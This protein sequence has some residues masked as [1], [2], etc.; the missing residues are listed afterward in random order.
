MKNILNFLA[1]FIMLGI[2][3]QSIELGNTKVKLKVGSSFSYSS[4]KIGDVVVPPPSGALELTELKAFPSAKGFAATTTTGGRGGTIYEVTSLADTNTPGTLRYAV[5]Q[6]GPRIVLIKTCGQITLGNVLDIANGNITIIG[7]TACGGGIELVGNGIFITSSNVIIR[8]IRIRRNE[9]PNVFSVNAINIGSFSGNVENVIIDHVSVAWGSDENFVIAAAGTNFGS[10]INNIT[11]QNSISSQNN[12]LMLI[13]STVQNLS[14]I[15]TYF[16]FGNDR[17]PLV[18]S[19]AQ[20][21]EVTNYLRAEM[22]NNVMYDVSSIGLITYGL[23]TSF[24]GNVYKR[25]TGNT[26]VYRY[27]LTSA[28]ENTSVDQRP[29]TELYLVDN[30]DINNGGLL[31]ENSVVIDPY[32]V[33]TPFSSSGYSTVAASSLN[34]LSNVGALPHDSNDADITARFASGAGPP[35]TGTLRGDGFYEYDIVLASG[36]PYTDTDGDGISDAFETAHGLNLSIAN[37]NS[38]TTNWPNLGDNGII[39]TAGYTDLE[40]FMEYGL[41]DFGN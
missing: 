41:I 38:V 16:A 9:L 40:M 24:V 26:D 39:N 30:I 37:S 22:L 36:T 27:N 28:G 31:N 32:K 14:V 23:K 18:S 11:I 15:N 13:S 35:T 10:S 8:N 2:H 34:I 4:V 20:N 5:N 19:F 3:A 21:N 1:L 12:H 29:N 17:A 7:Q 25:P 6:S 33:G